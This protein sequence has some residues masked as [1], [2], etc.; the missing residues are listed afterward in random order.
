MSD[1]VILETPFIRRFVTTKLARLLSEHV[2]FEGQERQLADWRTAERYVHEHLTAVD[3]AD[4]TLQFIIEAGDE[5]RE[6]LGIGKIHVNGVTNSLVARLYEHITKLSEEKKQE[7]ADRIL[8][9]Q[10]WY[11]YYQHLVADRAN[12]DQG[13]REVLRGL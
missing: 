8:K 7:Y 2:K 10:I 9:N 12:L 11:N 3:V 6:R 13:H 5:E 4:L 1:P